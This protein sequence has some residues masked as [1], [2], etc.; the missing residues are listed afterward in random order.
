[1]YLFQ[2]EEQGLQ[3]AALVYFHSLRSTYSPGPNATAKSAVG[4]EHETG[5]NTVAKG[6]VMSGASENHP[7]RRSGTLRPLATL[8]GDREKVQWAE[9]LVTLLQAQGHNPWQTQELRET[10]WVPHSGCPA[11]GAHPGC[12]RHPLPTAG[13]CFLHS[14]SRPGQLVGAFLSCYM[15]H[16]THFCEI[17]LKPVC[18]CPGT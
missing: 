12:P 11:L 10:A 3:E 15:Q 4:Q 8:E 1:M 16:N 5:L 14:C 6:P 7:D 17:L 2:K 13:T 9:P 18:N